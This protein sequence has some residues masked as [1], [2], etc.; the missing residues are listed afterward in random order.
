MSNITSQRRENWRPAPRPEWVERIN[1][2]GRWMDIGG[3]VPLDE[4]SLLN[5]AMK[6][7][8]LSDFGPDDWREPFRVYIKALEEEAELNLLGRIRT[9]SEILQFLC[10][11]LR[12]EEEYKRHPEIADEEIKQPIVV[13]GQGRSGTS[14]MLNTLAAAPSNGA[15]S[16]WESIYPCPPPEKDS[17]H[18]DPRVEAGHQI[19]DQWNRVT[20]EIAAMHEFDGRIPEECCHI[21]AINFMSVT[22]LNLL[23]QVPSYIQYAPQIDWTQ[24]YAYHKRI[25]KLLQWKNPRKHWVLKAPEHLDHLTDLLKVYPDACIVLMNRDPIKALASSLNLIGTAQWARTD[26]PL[27]SNAWDFIISAETSA[28][29]LESIIDLMEGGVVSKERVLNVLY[30]DLVADPLSTVDKI[31]DYFDLPMSGEERGVIAKYLADNPR[32]NRP[33]HKFDMGSDEQIAR[34]R[35]LFKRYQDYFHIPNEV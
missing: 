5:S 7:T 10:A 12:I 6:A 2:E 31:Y 18:S 27:S 11:R 24:C 26:N 16:T 21:M 8:G 4:Q 15:L 33:P 28:K 22:W 25:L 35:E 14:F 30:K 20:P 17:Y 9:R 1:E 13:I 23:G 3:I 29:R 34:E 32:E 19:A